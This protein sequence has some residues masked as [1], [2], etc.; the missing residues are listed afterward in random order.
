MKREAS[1]LILMFEKKK[2]KKILSSYMM[3]RAGTRFPSLE[4]PSECHSEANMLTCNSH[5]KDMKVVFKGV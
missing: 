2:E 1:E 4:S 5:S 3:H